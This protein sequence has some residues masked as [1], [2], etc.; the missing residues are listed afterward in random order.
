M[1]INIYLVIVC[2]GSYVKV[3]G[4]L[5]RLVLSLYYVGSRDQTQAISIG[6]IMPSHWPTLISETGSYIVQ[7]VLKLDIYLRLALNS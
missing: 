1:F 3:R 4:H 6:S 5:Q 7:T 2:S